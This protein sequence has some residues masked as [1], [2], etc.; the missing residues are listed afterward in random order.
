MVLSRAFLLLEG[1][2]KYLVP[3]PCMAV[4]GTP[5]YR[6][7]VVIPGYDQPTLVMPGT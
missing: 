4:H 3:M 7:Q 6:V 1:Q 2:R 5:C